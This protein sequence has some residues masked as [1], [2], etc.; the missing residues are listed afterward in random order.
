MFD[1][2]DE[3]DEWLRRERGLGFE[4]ILFHIQAGDLL[5]T[6]E[7]PN[8]KRYPGQKIMYVKVDDY[9]WMVPFVEGKIKF[10]KTIIPSRK[11]TRELLGE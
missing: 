11:A 6:A 9:I 4:D 10:L 1:W 3:K 8:Q 7:H 5:L 2:D